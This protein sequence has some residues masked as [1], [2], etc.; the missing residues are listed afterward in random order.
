[1]VG[2][3][4]DVRGLERCPL[5]SLAVSIR[6]VTAPRPRLLQHPSEGPWPSPDAPPSLWGTETFLE[7]FLSSVSLLSSSGPKQEGAD[8][9]PGTS[10]DDAQRVAMDVLTCDICL[11]QAVTRS[12][13]LSK[14]SNLKVP[15]NV[16][17]GFRAAAARQVPADPDTCT[18]S[19]KHQRQVKWESCSSLSLRTRVITLS[20]QF[21]IVS[22][23]CS[24]L[25]LKTFT[26]STPLLQTHLP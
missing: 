24:T 18:R 10:M 6:P 25:R 8:A 1:M 19:R 4:K 14:A 17:A 2:T 15:S 11:I 13:T 9:Y 5:L 26:S 7:T 22:G 21:Y 23:F 16:T 20:R 3:Y 12:M